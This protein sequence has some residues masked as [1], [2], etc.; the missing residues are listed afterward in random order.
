MN[1]RLVESGSVQQGDSALVVATRNPYSEE[2]KAGVIMIEDILPKLQLDIYRGRIQE[3]ND[4]YDFTVGS[5]SQ[6]LDLNWSYAN[7][8]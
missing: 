4:G 2:F 6:L 7:I 3:I 5:F 8:V 1:D